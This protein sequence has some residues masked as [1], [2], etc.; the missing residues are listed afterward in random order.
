MT[1]EVTLSGIQEFFLQPIIK[2][3]P[4]ISPLGHFFANTK[5]YRFFFHS[6]SIMWCSFRNVS[7]RENINVT[8]RPRV[9]GVW[10][11]AWM[12]SASDITWSPV[13]GNLCINIDI[14]LLLADV[15]LTWYGHL[16]SSDIFGL[17]CSLVYTGCLESNSALLQ[18][19][20]F[21]IKMTMISYFRI[22][23]PSSDLKNTK[24]TIL[25]LYVEKIAHGHDSNE[26]TKFQ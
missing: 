4:N 1:R 15:F 6:Y 24:N 14:F 7:Y 25:Y 10:T 2:D 23:S 22:S 18:W 8:L 13:L 3:R 11:S 21:I 20:H 9:V 5:E 17:T 26:L 16:I 12:C 19:C